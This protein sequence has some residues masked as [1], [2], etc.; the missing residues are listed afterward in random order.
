MWVRSYFTS[1]QF[2]YRTDDDGK[3]PI[4]RS[5]ELVF[6]RGLA[7][8]VD[9]IETSPDATFR[10]QIAW[11]LRMA[12]NKTTPG[13]L[14]YGFLGYSHLTI[15]ATSGNVGMHHVSPVTRRWGGTIA[16]PP[17]TEQFSV[18][19][20]AFPLGEIEIGLLILPAVWATRWIIRH[21]TPAPGHCRCGYNLAGNTSGKCPECGSVVKRNAGMS[22][23][24]TAPG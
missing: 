7:M 12:R 10:K 3:Q 11:T 18:R 5:R 17:W 1:D 14:G 23:I 6:T 22:V 8:Y 21:R 2:R 9:C 15:P 19:Q 16:G 4:Q 24:P 20:I 13:L